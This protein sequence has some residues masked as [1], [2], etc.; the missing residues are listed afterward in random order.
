MKVI[1]IVNL[2]GGVGKTVTAIN[3]AYILA[4]D[5]DKNV[6]VI[7]CDSQCNTTDFFGCG[8]D[9]GGVVHYLTGEREAFYGDEIISAAPGIDILAASDG[10][11]ALD[12]SK[13]E[14]QTVDVNALDDLCCVLDEDGAYDYVIID[15]PPAFTAA[16]TAALMATD[17]V[18]IPIKLDAFSLRGM[19][20]LMRQVETMRRV[21]SGLRVA[22]CLITMRGKSDTT[23][24][25]ETQ[26]RGLGLPVFRQSI[27]WSEMVDGMTFAQ[28]PITVF[29][30]RSAAGVD[31]RRFAREYLGG[32][33]G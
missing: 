19:A 11:M 26:L 33:M 2:K 4:D 6:L 21:N 28:Q 23:A 17:D 16:A 9:D 25:A 24:D 7:D 15:M 20:N 5:Y 32:E 27:R 22:G 8:T 12:L 1:S 30:P 18:I 14:E 3:L 31:Y 13:V 10:L 29:S